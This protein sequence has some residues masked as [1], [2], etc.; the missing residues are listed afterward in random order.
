MWRIVFYLEVKKKHSQDSFIYQ[1]EEVWNIKLVS[2]RHF[3]STF[4]HQ[5]RKLSGHMCCDI[6]SAILLLDYGGI[7]FLLATR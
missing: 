6:V 3:L 4:L 2:F 1:K 7:V 5:A